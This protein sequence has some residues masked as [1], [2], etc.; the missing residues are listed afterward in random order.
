MSSLKIDQYV[1]N[2]LIVTNI[3]HN[4]IL[5]ISLSIDNGGA[6]KVSP[7]NK[8]GLD[9]HISFNC[10]LFQ[11]CVVLLLRLPAELQQISW[12]T[13]LRTLS[14]FFFLYYPLTFWKALTSIVIN[15]QVSHLKLSRPNLYPHKF[16]IMIISCIP[17]KKQLQFIQIRVF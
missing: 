16:I 12:G 14:S 6:P 17:T 8:I 13:R 10:M 5:A 1:L 9:Y 3:L 7:W 11:F 15:L 4:M 2:A